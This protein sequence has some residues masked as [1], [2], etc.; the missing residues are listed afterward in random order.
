M[1][2]VP[3]GKDSRCFVAG[4]LF[5]AACVWIDRPRRA[6]APP[7]RET[8][9]G[10]QHPGDSGRGLGG[11]RK[12]RFSAAGVN[13]QRS[14][15]HIDS[16]FGQRLPRDG[17]RPSRSARQ[18]GRRSGGRISVPT[19]RCPWAGRRPEFIRRRGVE[20]SKMRALPAASESSQLPA[21]QFER[22]ITETRKESKTKWIKGPRVSGEGESDRS[23][24]LS[25]TGLTA[26]GS[27]A[28][29]KP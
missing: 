29:R 18:A 15:R 19:A 8:T 11:G 6:R 23:Q 2:L 10:Q 17:A 24:P 13:P 1:E 9:P 14:S 12:G 5:F 22:H 26:A 27:G 20:K 25:E 28:S 16:R 7:S 3:R 21:G 4:E